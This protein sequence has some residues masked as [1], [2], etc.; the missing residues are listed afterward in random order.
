VNEDHISYEEWEIAQNFI[1]ILLSGSNRTNYRQ[2]YSQS[3]WNE[4][5]P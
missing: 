2:V 1:D 4:H 5:G 3:E